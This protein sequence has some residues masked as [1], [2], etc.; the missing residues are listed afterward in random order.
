MNDAEKLGIIILAAG[1][2]KR[3]KSDLPKVLQKLCGRPLINYVLDTALALNPEICAVVLGFKNELVR[4]FISENVKIA[5]Q[6]PQLGTGHAVMQTAEIFEKFSGKILVLCGDVPLL[7]LLTLKKLINQYD[8]QESDAAILSA[9][10][11]DPSGYGRIVRN[12]NNEV[13]AI[14]EDKDADK[15]IKAIKEINSGIYCFNSKYLFKYLPN[16]K[17]TNAQ[18]EYYLTDIIDIMVK[19]K[20]KVIAVKSA[21]KIEIEGINNRLQLARLEKELYADTAKSHLENGVVI[22]DIENVYIDTLSKIGAETV[23][24]AGSV[25]MNSILGKNCVIDG[26]AIS[27]S[28]IKENC[29][30]G[31]ST[32]SKTKIFANVSI[33]DYNVIGDCE[34]KNNCAIG[35]NNTIKNSCIDVNT[36]IQNNCN[37]EDM[38]IGKNCYISNGFSVCNFDGFNNHTSKI[39]DFVFVGAGCQ[40]VSPVNINSNSYITS[41]STIIKD[42][43]EDSLIMARFDVV[44]KRG[45]MDKIKKKINGGE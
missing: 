23:I 11:D 1:L 13:S 7:K 26:G 5:I 24:M 31:K 4:P 18:S 35:N 16:I 43:E 20:H 45:Y 19:N 42:V 30:I 9:E 2:G 34:I 39:S 29:N 28:E 14:V 8:K 3:M 38:E 33:N 36:K 12:E 15:N 41:G 37:I 32:I 6:E 40:I 25:I 27:D 10:L 21:N 44:A 22:N 17:N